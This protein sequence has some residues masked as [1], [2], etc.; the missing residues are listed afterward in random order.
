MSYGVDFEGPHKC[1]T[2]LTVVSLRLFNVG[3]KLNSHFLPAVLSVERKCSE[4][5]A[6][7]LTDCQ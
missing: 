1:R 5:L 7:D 2:V 3:Q 6:G 4:E